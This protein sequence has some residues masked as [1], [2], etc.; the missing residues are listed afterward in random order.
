MVYVEAVPVRL[1]PLG[2]VNEVGTLLQGDA[3]GNMVRY[4]VSGRVLYRET[5]RAALLRHMEKDLGPLAFP[6]LPISPV[7][8]TVAEYFPAPSQTGFT[9]DRQHAVSLAYVIP[10]TGECDPRQDALELTWMTPQE[11]LS[12]N[13]QQEFDGGRGNL[14]RQAL[15]FSGV[16]L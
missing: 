5:I 7:P 15:S 12:E 3:D 4:L 9:D 14:V 1:D 8:F 11:V 6:Q 2:Y 13:V 10:V 16:V